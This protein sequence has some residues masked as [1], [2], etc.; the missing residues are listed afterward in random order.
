M[1]DGTFATVIAAQLADRAA[2]DRAE[3][4]PAPALRRLNRGGR[5]AVVAAMESVGVWELLLL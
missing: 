4:P 1:G 2:G 3:E 5:L